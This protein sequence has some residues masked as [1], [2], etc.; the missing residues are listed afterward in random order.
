MLASTAFSHSEEVCLNQCAEACATMWL[1]DDEGSDDSVAKH[2]VWNGLLQLFAHYTISPL[3]VLG[4]DDS[5]E[6]A[7]AMPCH[8]TLDVFTMMQQHLPSD[9]ETWTPQT[10]IWHSGAM[11]DDPS[12]AAGASSCRFL[13]TWKSPWR[14]G[15]VSVPSLCE[16]AEQLLHLDSNASGIC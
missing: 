11:C 7:V 1:D 13:A 16:A 12:T 3:L 8:F 9:D 10:R 15:H 5:I 2:N 6:L 4:L 14:V